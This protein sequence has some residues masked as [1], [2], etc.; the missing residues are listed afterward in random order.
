MKVFNQSNSEM[1]WDMTRA[2]ATDQKGDIWI[3]T[4]NGIVKIANGKWEHF[5]SSNTIIS[6][7][8]YNKNQTQS[9][10]DMEVDKKDNKWF[11]IGYDVYRYDNHIWTKFDSVNSPINWAREIFVDHSGNVLFTSWNGVSKFDGQKWSE[12]TKKNSKLPSDKTLGVFVDSKER[13]WIGTFEGNVIIDKGIT[14]PLNDRS[15]PLSKAYISKMYEDKKG[16]LWFSLYNE[17]GTGA[18]IYIQSP[19][20]KWKEYLLKIPKCLLAIAIMTFFRRRD[21]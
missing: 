3:G 21:W 8:S 9:V 19:N 12:M 13:T 2:V 11:I 16:N 7:T 1:P 17:K 10:R 14:T 5:N 20:G 6:P 4:D 18:G 15:T